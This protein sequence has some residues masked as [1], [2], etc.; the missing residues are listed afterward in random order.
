MID[1]ETKIHFAK[2]SHMKHLAS[3]LLLVLCSASASAQWTN[4]QNASFVIGQADFYSAV[5]ATTATGLFYPYDVAV[6]VAHSKLYVNDQGNGRILRYGLPITKNQPTPECVF[7]APTFTTASYLTSFNGTN[8]ICVANGDLW[9]TDR[10]NCRVLKFA[11][12]YQAVNGAAPSVVIGQ[13]DFSVPGNGYVISQTG[14]GQPW[15]VAVDGGGNLWVSDYYRILCYGQAST[16]GNGASA[17]KVLGQ[18]DYTSKDYGFIGR[19]IS[20]LPTRICFSGN[21]LWAFD[22]NFARIARFD[23][24]AT[25][26]NGA[27]ADGILGVLDFSNIGTAVTQTG[28]GHG[29]YGG[30]LS[31]DNTGRLFVAD[32]DNNR[33]MIYNAAASKPNGAPAD[34]VLG[35]SDFTSNISG[36]N[37]SRL[38]SPRGVASDGA[39]N[40]Y[41]ADFWNSRVLVFNSSNPQSVDGSS[42]VPSV[43]TLSQNYPNPFNPSTNITFTV[44]TTGRATVTIFNMLGQEVAMPFNGEARAGMPYQVRFNASGLPSGVYFSR[45]ET[46]GEVRVK[47]MQLLK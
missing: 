26:G 14:L 16:L 6:D 19:P 39:N 11:A 21:T 36:C 45:L 1:G 7:G 2:G 46:N 31:V 5:L 22:F 9:V 30:G 42:M 34:V 47:K 37:K 3:T 41:V 32:Y 8:G 27:T 12:A 24:A 35:Q 13:P 23:N 38:F 18:P 10:D 44:K 17:I 29:I 43:V 28:F 20:G 40:L 33:I 25:K 4:N 15:S